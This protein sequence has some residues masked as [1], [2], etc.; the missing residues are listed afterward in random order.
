MEGLLEAHGSRKL[1]LPKCHIASAGRVDDPSFLV[2][3]GE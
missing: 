2:D 1:D 3:N